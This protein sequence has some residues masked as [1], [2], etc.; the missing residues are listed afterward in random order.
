MGASSMLAAEKLSPLTVVVR[1]AVERWLAPPILAQIASDCAISNYERKVTLQ[2]LTG[3]MLDA[4]LGMQPT[5]HAAAIAR[6]NEW[7][8]S[9]QALY[10]KLGR[11]DP[12][13]S[14][15]L[16]RRTA[17]GI[18]PLVTSRRMAG[19]PGNVSIKVLDGT[20]PDGSEHRL[21]VLR[22]L[23]AAGLPA[24]AVIVYD[25]STGV[26]DRVAVDEDAYASEKVLAEAVL[27]EAAADEIYIADRG[28]CTCRLMGQ[29]LGR[30]SSFIFREHA[31]DLVYEEESR[32]RSCGRCSSGVVLEGTVRLCDRLRKCT[33]DLRR[34][35][36]Q[37]DAP[38]QSG[39]KDLLLLTNLPT[40]CLAVE[41]ADLYRQRWQVERH[42]HFI[43]RELHGQIPSLGE[44][45]AA[46]FALCVSLAAGNVL[47]FVKHLQPEDKAAVQ[48]PVLSGYYLA[49]EISRS[50]AA[51]EALTTPRDWQAIA[52]LSSR[53]FLTWAKQQATR[54]KWQRYVTHPRGPKQR[55]PP[56]LSGKHRHHFSTYRLLKSQNDQSRAC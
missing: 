7:Q 45:R 21:G 5:V 1:G 3:I 46:I 4:V 54:I 2:A 15:G 28:F 11:V 48:R 16:V 8:G 37:L 52:K 55:P 30:E 51:I 27:Q 34:F 42:F 14:M 12:K 22:E 36:V 33:W 50:Y 17:E 23:A 9:I 10:A 40:D 47:A 53:A 19:K 44:P 41:I 20:M 32:E 24:Q 35:H 13:F 6:R 18:L 38:T 39:E 26:C 49:L 31:Y 43:K 56:R 25:L 29:L